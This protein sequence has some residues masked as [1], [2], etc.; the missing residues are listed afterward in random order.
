M[1]DKR[2]FPQF[3][4]Q[5]AWL[6]CFKRLLEERNPLEFPRRYK[7]ELQVRRENCLRNKGQL[8]QSECVRYLISL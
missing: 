4:G 1:R 8:H 2:E 3:T 6:A 7:R 5:A